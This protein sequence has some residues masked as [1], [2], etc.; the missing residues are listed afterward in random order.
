MAL[1]HMADLMAEHARQFL[2][3]VGLLHQPVE[4]QH[5]PAGQG[6][7]VYHVH[8]GDARAHFFFCRVDF[9]EQLGERCIARWRMADAAAEIADHG[10][11][12]IA[13]PARRDAG[14]EPVRG[15]HEQRNRR[16]AGDGEDRGRLAEAQ[17][18]DPGAVVAFGRKLR[19]KSGRYI[20]WQDQ[21]EVRHT[22][23][24]VEDAIRSRFTEAQIAGI[25]FDMRGRCGQRKS[26]A[27]VPAQLARMADRIRAVVP[28]GRNLEGVFHRFRSRPCRRRRAGLRRVWRSSFPTGSVRRAEFRRLPR[29]AS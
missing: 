18:V 4:Q 15:S 12:D 16:R 6:D 11:S 5:L 1:A 3:A 24:A 27:P 20:L 19:G 2:G 17:P 9:G 28:F 26:S 10:I 22:L 13:F 23:A 8:I 7:R 21:P 14:A 29:D 25:E